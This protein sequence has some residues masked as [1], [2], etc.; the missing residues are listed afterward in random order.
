MG[1]NSA[2]AWTDHTFNPVWGCAKVDACCTNCYAET[3]AHRY[4]FEWGEGAGRRKFGDKHW[5]E[6]LRWNAKAVK[7]G[8]PAR[9]FCGSMCDVFEDR[10]DLDAERV[11]LW[12]LI[13]ATPAL[14][15]LLLTKRPQNIRAMLPMIQ[16]GSG[17]LPRF[18]NVWVGATVGHRGVLHS[19]DLL[20][21][22][23]AAVR[24]ISAE[25]LLEDLG[26]IDLT[27]IGWVIVGCESGPKARPMEAEWAESILK[28]CQVEGVPFFLKQM[29]VAGRLV[30]LPLLSGRTWSQTP[31]AL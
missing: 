8:Q 29:K 18:D 22:V 10:R 14:T 26:P 31:G 1:E 21:E 23:P 5:N 6:P 20:R 16:I 4:G 17:D 19:I 7:A 25:P 9:V 27:G 28:Q 11:R 12:K 24:F 3:L 30:S 15:W 13:E 2:I